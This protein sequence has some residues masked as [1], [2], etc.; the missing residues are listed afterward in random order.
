MRNK[1]GIHYIENKE[2]QLLEQKRLITKTEREYIKKNLDLKKHK[3]EV[4][5]LLFMY[6]ISVLSLSTLFY[7]I[8]SI[9]GAVLTFTI[10]NLYTALAVVPARYKIIKLIKHEQIFVREAIFYSINRYHH[11]CFEI[12]NDGKRKFVHMR[13]DLHD[14]IYK[15]D[16][17]ILIKIR[18]N[19]SIVYLARE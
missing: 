3:K 10:V 18:R 12:V 19:S 16:K 6:F 7:F 14:P 2:V 15:G 4:I 9:K 5:V 17:V 1:T 13:A 11:A 8:D